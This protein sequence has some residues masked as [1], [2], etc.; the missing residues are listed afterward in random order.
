M[1]R[2]RESKVRRCNAVTIMVAVH[3]TSFLNRAECIYSR[4]SRS[5]VCIRYA[6]RVQ[7]S[8]AGSLS[9]VVLDGRLKRLRRG[10]VIADFIRNGVILRECDVVGERLLVWRLGIG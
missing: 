5:R 10:S 9:R 6:P 1:R 3:E 7:V 4:C 8:R 2:W